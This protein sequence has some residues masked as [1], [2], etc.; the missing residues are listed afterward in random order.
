MKKPVILLAER[1]ETQRRNVH[2]LLRGDG[3]VVIEATDTTGIFRAF[4]QKQP[5]AL[6]LI[7]ASLDAPDDGLQIARQ[8]RQ[9]HSTL[10]IMVMAIHSSEELAIAALKAGVTDYFRPPFSEDELLTSVRRCLTD[11]CP[12]TGLAEI[13]VK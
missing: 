8:V 9:G 10:P 2:D 11:S 6:L 13:P 5:L 4:R 3:F 12:E 1:D 7:N